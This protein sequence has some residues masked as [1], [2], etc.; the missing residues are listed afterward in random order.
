VFYRRHRSV[1]SFIERIGAEP[2]RGSSETQ[3]VGGY[4]GST[5]QLTLRDYFLGGT[6]ALAITGGA[7]VRSTPLVS[8]SLDERYER[9]R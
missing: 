5:S 7:L 3:S 8:G 1:E 9:R 2:L 4:G 6:D